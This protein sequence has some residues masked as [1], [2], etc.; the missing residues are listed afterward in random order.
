MPCPQLT[1]SLLPC[2]S[3]GPQTSDSP[4]PPAGGI[5]AGLPDLPNGLKRADISTALNLKAMYTHDLVNA[6]TR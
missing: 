4:S 2:P 6:H 1:Q 3:C 5:P